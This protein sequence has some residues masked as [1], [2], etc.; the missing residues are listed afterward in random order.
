MRG[1]SSWQAWS[2][3]SLLGAEG[4]AALQAAWGPGRP[5]AGYPSAPEHDRSDGGRACSLGGAN[6]EAQGEGADHEVPGR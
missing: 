3:L 1:P 4:P 2:A 6:A 5:A